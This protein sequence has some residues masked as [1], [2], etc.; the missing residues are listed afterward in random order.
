MSGLCDEDECLRRQ[1]DLEARLRHLEE[2]YA[3]LAAEHR[4]LVRTVLASRRS[5]E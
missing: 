4:A 1:E 3:E 5:V 2:V